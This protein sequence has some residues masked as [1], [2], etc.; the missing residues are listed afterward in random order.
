MTYS[1]WALRKV[2]RFYR[3]LPSELAD[4]PEDEIVTEAEMLEI[5]EELREMAITEAQGRG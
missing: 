2:A 3:R 1:G 5:E 4:V